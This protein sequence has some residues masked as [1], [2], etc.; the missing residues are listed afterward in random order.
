MTLTIPIP[1]WPVFLKISGVKEFFFD[2]LPRATQNDLWAYLRQ[3]Q[4]RYPLINDL[5]FLI[6]AEATAN[7]SPPDTLILAVQFG[8]QGLFQI[9]I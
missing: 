6:P 1:G 7:I 3:W 5:A 4:L 9:D 8:Q 2:F